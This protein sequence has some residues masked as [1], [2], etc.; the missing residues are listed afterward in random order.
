ME[1]PEAATVGSESPAQVIPARNLMHRFIS[2]QFFEDQRRRP[3]VDTLELEKAAV[4]PGAEEMSK[5][6]VHRR[7]LGM[8]FNLP[9]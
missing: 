9:Q 6:R 1:E 2:N 5:V 7:E 3:P 4:E 8:G